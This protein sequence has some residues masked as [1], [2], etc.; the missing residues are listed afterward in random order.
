MIKLILNLIVRKKLRPTIKN[1]IFKKMKNIKMKFKI[2][3]IQS[4]L[5][6]DNMQYKNLDPQVH[7]TFKI[8]KYIKVSKFQNLWKW[9]MTNR[10]RASNHNKS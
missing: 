6:K 8:I 9:I 5:K 1:I 7:K 4:K 3:R 2:N 10:L